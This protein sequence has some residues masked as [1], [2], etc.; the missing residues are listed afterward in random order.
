MLIVSP[1]PL[2]S[3]TPPPPPQSHNLQGACPADKFQTIF[4]SAVFVGSI[5][6]YFAPYLTFESVKT[7]LV[8]V[9]D[10]EQTGHV[11]QWWSHGEQGP[12]RGVTQVPLC[13]EDTGIKGPF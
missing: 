13:T 12:T 6:T 9:N 1:F 11:S 8:Y 2:T 3:A 5:P 4:S 10:T 7:G